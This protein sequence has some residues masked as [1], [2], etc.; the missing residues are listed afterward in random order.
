MKLDIPNIGVRFLYLEVEADDLPN[1]PELEN[2]NKEELFRSLDGGNEHKEIM[3]PMIESMFRKSSFSEL[4][5]NFTASFKKLIV[6]ASI[7]KENMEEFAEEIPE[8]A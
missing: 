7:S 3:F 6:E 5:K 8:P 2:E 4:R 1:L